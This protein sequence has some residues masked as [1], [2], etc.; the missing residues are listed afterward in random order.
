MAMAV[1]SA[2][3]IFQGQD[4]MMKQRPAIVVLAAGRG[5]R[6]HGAGHKLEQQLKETGKTV[7][8]ATLGHALETGL[9][10]V[11]V[12]SARM[13][14]AA[15]RLIAAR[16][17]VVLSELDSH[18]RP[19]PEG[20]G[21]SIAAGVSASGDADGW[22]IVPADMPLLSPSSMLAVASALEQYPIAFAQHRGR[23]G[24][25]VGFSAELYSELVVLQG[26]EGARRILVRYPSQGIEIDDAGV[27]VDVDTVED[28]AA[29][30][31]G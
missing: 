5:M 21:Y 12:T 3:A 6:F 13:A 29:L 31:A 30:Q 19:N 26:D 22:L 7:L 1:Q 4:G 17:V 2:D 24:H 9:R 15:N 23:R 18:G 16:N 20:M 25:P 8:S 11:V 27:L 28:L 14:P 10:V